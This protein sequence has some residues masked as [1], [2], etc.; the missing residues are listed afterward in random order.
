M[1]SNNVSSN[2]LNSYIHNFQ[3]VIVRR[4]CDCLFSVCL[5]LLPPEQL[6]QLDVRVDKESESVVKEVVYLSDNSVP[7][8]GGNSS[9]LQKRGDGIR[10]N[11][12][13]GNQS[14]DQRE[15]SFKVLEL[16]SVMSI[17]V[18]CEMIILSRTINNVV[19]LNSD[20]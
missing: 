1:A 15:K 14:F 8:A 13:T 16:S 2:C 9:I 18:I 12:F 19:L 3:I 4:Y 11:L 20:Y 5:K 7:D 10:F 17:L 6:E